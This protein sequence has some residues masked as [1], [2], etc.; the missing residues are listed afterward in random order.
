[1]K[2]GIVGGTG[3]LGRGL[4][5]RWAAAGHDIYVGSRD[6]TRAE[7]AVQEMTEALQ[8]AAAS[9]GGSMGRLHPADNETAAREGEVAVLAVPSVADDAFLRQLAEPLAGKL[10][11]DCTVRLDPEDVTRVPADHTGSA[12]RTR[13]VLGPDVRVVGAFHTVS[14]TK[15]VRLDRT[16]EE[17]TFVVGDDADDVALAM[18]LA[19]DA[20]L[21]AFHAGPL[22]TGLT[23]E[24]ITAMLIGLNKRYRRRGIGIRLTG[25]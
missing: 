4:A 16:L 24:R 21:R 20:G 8:G 22:E 13:D 11:I 17:D 9:D 25:V 6:Q 7:A 1:M 19:E 15:L 10:L 3:P 5:L 2:I 12:L 23:L 18:K 14:A